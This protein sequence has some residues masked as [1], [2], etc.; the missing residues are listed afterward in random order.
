MTIT[1]IISNIVLGALVVL[2][3]VMFGQRAADLERRLLRAECDLARHVTRPHVL[4]PTAT[5]SRIVHH[6]VRRVSEN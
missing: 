6:R 2:Q 3:W 1:L 4:M 5:V